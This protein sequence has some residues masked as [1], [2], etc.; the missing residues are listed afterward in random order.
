MYCHQ[1][2]NVGYL[3]YSVQLSLFGGQIGVQ[4]VVNEQ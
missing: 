1:R 4:A 2:E 3:A